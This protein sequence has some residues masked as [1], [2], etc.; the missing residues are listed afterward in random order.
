LPIALEMPLIDI[1][2]VGA[3]LTGGDI[4]EL[5]P[6]GS[7]RPVGSAREVTNADLTWSCLISIATWQ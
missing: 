6:R 5:Q 7:L 1:E 3:D 2:V 4:A